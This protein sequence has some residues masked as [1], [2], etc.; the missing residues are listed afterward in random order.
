M[1]EIWKDIHNYEKY[2]QVSDSGKI[3]S[4]NRYVKD[5]RKTQFIKG[6]ILKPFDNG[7]EYM[8]VSLLKDGKKK[9]HY[10]HRL[11][12]EHFIDDFAFDKVVNHKNFNKEQC[13][14]GNLEMMTQQENIKYSI[15]HNRYKNAHIQNGVERRKKSLLRVIHNQKTILDRYDNGESI[16]SISK[17]LHLKIENVRDFVGKKRREKIICVETGEQFDTIKDANDKYGVTTIG[18]A[19]L[20][21]QKT[22]AGYHWMKKKYKIKGKVSWMELYERC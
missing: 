2:Y 10:V 17:S 19:I 18:D 15:V 22:S 9:N 21:R 11:V 16:D 12:A 4:L 1:E 5:S 14:I 7:K 20:G 3:R 13:G 6:K 8:M